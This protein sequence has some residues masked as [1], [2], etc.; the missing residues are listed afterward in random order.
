MRKHL[1]KHYPHRAL[2]LKSQISVLIV[3]GI[4]YR[5]MGEKLGLH[6]TTV[7][8]EIRRNTDG[9]EYVPLVAQTQAQKRCKSQDLI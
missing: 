2:E 8:R 6:H 9:K 5:S 3:M 7:S 4:S 1:R